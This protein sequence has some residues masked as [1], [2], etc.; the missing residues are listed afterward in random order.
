MFRLASRTRWGD[1]GPQA[2]PELC[3]KVWVAEHAKPTDGVMAAWADG[4][5]KEIASMTVEEFEGSKIAAP[6]AHV[7]QRKQ[8]ACGN[9]WEGVRK[10]WAG[11]KL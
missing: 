5:V 9:L 2:A 4:M 7:P 10:D 3:T 11:G 1:S 8:R 6:E